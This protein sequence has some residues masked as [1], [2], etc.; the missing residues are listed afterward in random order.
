MRLRDKK[1][2]KSQNCQSGQIV[3][4][5]SVK[6]TI[7]RTNNQCVDMKQPNLSLCNPFAHPS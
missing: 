7:L 6:F 1:A 3:G 4:K 2:T 5:S